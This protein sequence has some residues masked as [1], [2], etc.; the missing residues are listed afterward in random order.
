M[1]NSK[2]L[3]LQI[4]IKIVNKEAATKQNALLHA[5]H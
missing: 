1:S 5:Q 3:I 4:E 2:L